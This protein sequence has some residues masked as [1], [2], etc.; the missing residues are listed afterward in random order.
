MVAALRRRVRHLDRD[1][2]VRRR[3][4]DRRAAA[5]R[6]G[7]PLADLAG[8]ERPL[9]RDDAA[10][11]ARDRHLVRVVRLRARASSCPT[12]RRAAGA[13]TVRRRGAARRRVV[14]RAGR[15]AVRRLTRARAGGVRAVLRAGLGDLAAVAAVLLDDG[16]GNA[17]A[18]DLVAA[19]R[20]RGS[21]S[22]AACR[23]RGRRSRPCRTRRR[24][25]ARSR[26]A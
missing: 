5:A 21:T 18:R 19:R 7:D 23:H 20:R 3:R 17:A 9:L 15:A 1:V 10:D 6:A 12:C 22:L 24:S 2:R 11:G 26:W 13:V 4:A 14:D 8:R 25:S 16:A